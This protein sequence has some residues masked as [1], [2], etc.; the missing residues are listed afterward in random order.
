MAQ[1]VRQNHKSFV[2]V[3]FHH[4]NHYSDSD[5]DSDRVGLLSI[6]FPSEK[7]N[8]LF[9]VLITEISHSEGVLRFSPHL[10][11][12]DSGSKRECI[13]ITIRSIA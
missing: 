13:C 9:F 5:S 1:V 10:E 4:M 11:R 7:Y 8:N 6:F 12:F 2:M 3:D